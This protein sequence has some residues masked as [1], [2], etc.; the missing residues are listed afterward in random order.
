MAKEEKERFIKELKY[1]GKLIQ[2]KEAKEDN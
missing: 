2:E 1:L